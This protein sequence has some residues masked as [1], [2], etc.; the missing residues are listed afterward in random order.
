MLITDIGNAK[1]F[2]YFYILKK[3]KLDAKIKK[4]NSK[5]MAFYLKMQQVLL[6]SSIKLIKVLQRGSPLG[7]SPIALRVQ[8]STSM[9]AN[10][11]VLQEGST[12][13]TYVL[14]VELLLQT[15]WVTVMSRVAVFNCRKCYNFH[16]LV[17]NSLLKSLQG[18]KTQRVA[19]YSYILIDMFLFE[20][21]CKFNFL[22]F[23][24]R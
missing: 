15:V 2:Q 17:H 12:R 13:K 23:L 11:L 5:G 19:P 4:A 3:Q 18:H 6:L 1:Y 8:G 7:M 14:F 9:S 21:L 22:A 10:D 20:Y 24:R 16:S